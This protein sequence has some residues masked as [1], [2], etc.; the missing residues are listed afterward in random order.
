MLYTLVKKISHQHNTS[1][2]PHM[3]QIVNT[4]I[5]FGLWRNC[6]AGLTGIYT[7]ACIHVWCYLEM[8]LLN[9]VN[10]SGIKVYSSHSDES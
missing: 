2:C 4:Q 6:S 10:I 7:D 5:E 9:Y 8:Q 1:T 3:I